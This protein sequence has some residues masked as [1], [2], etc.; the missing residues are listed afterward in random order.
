MYQISGNVSGTSVDP[1]S[2]DPWR[3]QE[4]SLKWYVVQCKTREEERAHYF[5]KKKNLQVY[6][7][8]MEV[9]S[10]RGC[11][12]VM[13][14]KPLFPGYLFCRF[15]P[16]ESLAHVRWTKGVAK[17]LPESVK[18]ISIKEPVIDAIRALEQKDGIIRKKLLEKN[19]RIRIARGPMKHILGI[20][21]QW[22]S[23]KGRARVL[24]NFVTYQASVELHHSFVEKIV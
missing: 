3:N 18:P 9:V 19:D 15:N 22:T 12:G 4:E 5:L 8:R 23:D 21:D 1:Y 7:P 17:I 20:F 24:L 14:Q 11:Q 2:L 10:T 13:K 16:E 6:L